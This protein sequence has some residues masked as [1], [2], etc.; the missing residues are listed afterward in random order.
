[1]STIDTI[2][3]WMPIITYAS[4]YVEFVK[5]NGFETVIDP[6]SAEHL[7]LTLAKYDVKQ[8]FLN[9]CRS[10]ALSTAQA[11][12]AQTLIKHGICSVI[13]MSYNIGTAAAGIFVESFYLEYL[14]PNAT[15][16]DATSAARNSMLRNKQRATKFDEMIQ[17]Q[18][19]IVPIL[20]QSTFLFKKDDL[21]LS[22]L[23]LQV[24]TI[25]PDTVELGIPACFGREMHILDLESY[26]SRGIPV[27]LHGQAGIGKTSLLDEVSWWWQSTG[28]IGGTVYIDAPELQA[29]VVGCVR[30]QVA[31]ALTLP[32]ED[33]EES[34][35]SQL[36]ALIKK[37]KLLFII[38]NLESL[39]PTNEQE[40]LNLM[41]DIKQLLKPL[42]NHM[43]IIASRDVEDWISSFVPCTYGLEGLDERD[44]LKFGL[45][46]V[47][48][49]EPQNQELSRDD[50]RFFSLLL[51]LVAGVPLGIQLLMR[52]YKE[53]INN[54]PRLSCK[55]F[56]LRLLSV[57]VLNFQSAGAEWARHE[58]GARCVSKIQDMVENGIRANS[59]G[60][61]VVSDASA[62]VM[63]DVLQLAPF[64]LYVPY[65]IED[66]WLFL[67]MAMRRAV[68]GQEIAQ[69]QVKGENSRQGSDLGP[70]FWAG[71][72]DDGEWEF[73]K[74]QV[75]SDQATRFRLME[76]TKASHVWFQRIQEMSALYLISG[77]ITK[78]LR[79]RQGSLTKQYY[80]VNPVFTLIARSYHRPDI[81]YW[82]EVI[83]GSFRRFMFSQV[84]Q[85]A[86]AG[87]SNWSWTPEND[88]AREEVQF[89]FANF[90]AS[91]R[92]S[93]WTEG[94]R[95]EEWA[96]KQMCILSVAAADHEPSAWA[97]L[98]I[99]DEYLNS[100]MEFVRQ[101]KQKVTD[102]DGL[103]LIE[104]LFTATTGHAAKIEKYCIVLLASCALFAETADDASTEFKKQ[105]SELQ[106][107][108][109]S[110]HPKYST[111]EERS[112]NDLCL[113]VG[114]RKANFYEGPNEKTLEE[115]TI[116]MKEFKQELEKRTS[117]AAEYWDPALVG[118]PI[119]EAF[120]RISV[121]GP[122]SFC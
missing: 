86:S 31:L 105:K 34:T 32:P 55:K 19:H 110:N 68:E 33:F 35:F 99:Y 120:G 80:R 91:S 107:L 112:W 3:G 10:A 65:K 101:E 47:R 8:V 41:S 94:F 84:S 43:V 81:S 11:S 77:P 69:K 67:G 54:E 27:L 82:H 12:V 53:Y 121:G 15:I 16:I 61:K 29:S 59:Y 5:F 93:I 78:T 25:E 117:R 57:D 37:Q 50:L 45:S 63:Q 106:N 9:A 60:N 85:W 76:E 28:L 20:Y 46:L 26:V 58:K 51:G 109:L 52:M 44:A 66:Y 119:G 104:S 97:T 73:M 42:R 89:S 87:P 72:F 83:L 96:F 14:R 79:G 71:A 74:G 62:E 64:W 18:D 70:T 98:A 113:R 7:A 21:A 122:N 88:L 108:S 95:D 24:E 22:S 100:T 40:T 38:D 1:M 75:S 111:P 13:G 90:A 23:N 49:L 118:T 30:R 116:I 2:D 102:V 4:S 114:Q 36:A 48:E 6:V 56:Y 103:A 39:Q 17:V 92:A 115:C